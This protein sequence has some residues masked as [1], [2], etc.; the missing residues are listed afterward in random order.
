MNTL[1]ELWLIRHGQSLGQLD[2]GADQVNPDLT[3][4]GESQAEQLRKR[5]KDNSFDK[6]LVSPLTRSWR[7]FQLSGFVSNVVVADCRLIE[8]DF[9][10]EDFYSNFSLRSCPYEIQS[11]SI[12]LLTSSIDHRVESLINDIRAS[13]SGRVALFG[14]WGVFMHLLNEAF[15]IRHEGWV[16]TEMGNCSISVLSTNEKGRFKLEYWNIDGQML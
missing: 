14:H 1:V 4:F 3:P 11:A 2:P 5:V 7:T 8:S 15:G 6:V 13:E 12:N 16:L 10:Q 9:G